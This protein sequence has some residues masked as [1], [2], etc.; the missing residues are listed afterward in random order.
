[1][2]LNDDGWF[3]VSPFRYIGENTTDAYKLK[4]VVGEYSFINHGREI[5][6]LVKDF[7]SIKLN[8]DGSITGDIEGSFYFDE[9]N[10][11]TMSIDGEDYKG[12]VIKQ[13]DIN[14]KVYTMTFTLMGSENGI[15]LWGIKK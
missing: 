13:Y 10:K 12:V 14:R 4:D 3:V 11:I 8:K 5:W 1:M 9:G 6:D 15:A 2:Y 7:N